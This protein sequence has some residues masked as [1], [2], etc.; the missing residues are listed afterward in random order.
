MRKTL[1]FG[2]AS[3]KSRG[4]ERKKE[5]EKK[6]FLITNKATIDHMHHPIRKRMSWCV[7]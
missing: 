3:T 1:K 2:M 4:E 5:K 7:Q 6:A